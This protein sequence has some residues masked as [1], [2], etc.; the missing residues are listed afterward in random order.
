MS[1]QLPKAVIDGGRTSSTSGNA[2]INSNTV[3][4]PAAARAVLT[5]I[6]AAYKLAL[7]QCALA[8]QA[9]DAA[10]TSYYRA[11][12]SHYQEVEEARRTL[13]E[14]EEACAHVS[15]SQYDSTN[16]IRRGRFMRRGASLSPIPPDE[17][18]E[19]KSSL[20]EA[21]AGKVEAEECVRNLE[22]SSI[23]TVEK[24]HRDYCQSIFDQWKAHCASKK[25][26]LDKMRQTVQDQ[27]PKKRR[28]FSL[29]GTFSS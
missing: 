22:A 8:R 23:A 16:N 10:V 6:E 29:G 26:A 2:P 1:S 18:R 13:A 27:A 7:E 20:E 4:S 15:A 28:S 11:V 9:H 21:I 12:Q 5:G 19:V 24:K 14:W 17:K 25:T 3:V